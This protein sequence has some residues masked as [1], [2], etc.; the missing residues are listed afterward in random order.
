MCISPIS[1]FE[2][3]CGSFGCLVS[4]KEKCEHIHSTQLIVYIFQTFL[5]K[6]MV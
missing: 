5:F 6:V 3:V 4:S 2:G 1:F